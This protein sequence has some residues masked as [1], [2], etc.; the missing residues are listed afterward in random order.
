MGEEPTY[1]IGCYFPEVGGR[2]PT[3]DH[4][5]H[6]ELLE[7]SDGSLD[8]FYPSLCKPHAW[9]GINWRLSKTPS[10]KVCRRCE[11]IWKRMVIE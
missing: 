3:L 11:K 1:L 10:K 8:G 4:I 5:L 9:A 2:T 6:E 7:G